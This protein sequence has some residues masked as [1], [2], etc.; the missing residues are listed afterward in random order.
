MKQFILL[1]SISLLLIIISCNEETVVQNPTQTGSIFIDS[2]PQRA[3]IFLLGTNTNK[4][5]P[6]SILNLESGDY[7]LTLKLDGYADTTVVVNVKNGLR[8]TVFIDFDLTTGILIVKSY[9][10]GAQIFLNS[11]L[12]NYIT[13]D[14]IY[15]LISGNY[16]VSLSRE[17]YNSFGTNIFISKG[18]ISVLDVD[19]GEN[20]NYWWTV[21]DLLE[22][23]FSDRHVF[24]IAI[25]NFNVKW[26]GIGDNGLARFD[27]NSWTFYNQN[28]SELPSNY[29]IS[30][31]VDLLNNVW[32]GT[33]DGGLCKF[34]GTDWLIYNT[35][36]SDI[37]GNEVRLIEIDKNNI[38]WAL[39]IVSGSHHLT[40]F[41][42]SEFTIYDSTNTPMDLLNTEIRDICSSKNGYI[43]VGSANNGIYKSDGF[44]WEEDNS[45]Y[46]IRAIYEHEDGIVWLVDKEGQIFR[47]NFGNWDY[48]TT[49]MDGSNK[50]IVFENNTVWV[51]GGGLAKFDGERWTNYANVLRN[52]LPS[53]GN[54]EQIV[55]DNEN[56]K[57]IA[58]GGVAKRK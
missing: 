20:I 33:L 16:S 25:D 29:V 48:Y 23:D 9:P 52:L 45:V 22:F 28:N 41:N 36:N 57:W 35:S 54:V 10:A 42:G 37:P 27:D 6:D 30:L 5:T 3:M 51:G 40:M 17:G 53:G 56:N 50:T 13:P 44:G 21:F 47:G 24:G 49:R 46:D 43:L 38:V 34:N 26:M 15:S 8:T 11:S 58:T 4:L 14:T 2:N 31:D 39:V 12:T 7:E 32:V 1:L 18:G 19:L 55:L